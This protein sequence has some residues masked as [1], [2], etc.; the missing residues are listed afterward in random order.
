MV[1]KCRN[2]C[3]QHLGIQAKLIRHMLN[4]LTIFF[5][6]ITM[7]IKRLYLHHEHN[8]ALE[9][10]LEELQGTHILMVPLLSE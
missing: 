6:L 3:N 8:E 1:L 7:N 4:A 5:M 2:L 10:T 9:F